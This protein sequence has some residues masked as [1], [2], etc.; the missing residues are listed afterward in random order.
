MY[1][2]S[3]WFTL[4]ISSLFI[5]KPDGA[6]DFFVQFETE[7]LR[8]VIWQFTGLIERSLLEL[9][10]NSNQSELANSFN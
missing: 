2:I 8:F 6:R 4:S 3:E 5:E 10:L 7:N 1:Q 9:C